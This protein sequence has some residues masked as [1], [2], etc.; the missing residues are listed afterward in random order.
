MRYWLV[1]NRAHIQL[2]GWI[3]LHSLSQADLA[4][5]LHA[6]EATVSR[7]LSGERIPSLRMAIRIANLTGIQPTAWANAQK[8]AVA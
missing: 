1:A 2:R 7:L 8:A 4:R 5:E 6:S 3:Q